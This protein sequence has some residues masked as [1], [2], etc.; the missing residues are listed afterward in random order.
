MKLLR[1][2]LD[3]TYSNGDYIDS[4]YFNEEINILKKQ[5][6]ISDIRNACS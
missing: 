5:I 3:K 4:P 2:V 6:S 1:K